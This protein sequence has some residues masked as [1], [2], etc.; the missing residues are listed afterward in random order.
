MKKTI[1]FLTVF[2]LVLAFFSSSFTAN[3]IQ[4]IYS[5][6]KSDETSV[7]VSTDGVKELRFDDRMDITEKKVEVIDDGIPT[8]YQVGYGI[9]E[10]SVF[11]TAVV[12]IQGDTLIATGIGTAVVVIDGKQTEIR[13]TAAPISLFLLIGQSNMRGS[14]GN[15]NQSIACMD[16]TVYS[17]FGDD[18]GDTEGIMNINN[19]TN[20]APSALT[21]EYST[22]N[23]NGNTDNLSYY[24]V[25]SLTES[26][27][28]KFGPD[29]GF[30]YEWVM[31]TGEKVWLVNAAHG[32]SAIASWQPGAVN[33]KEAVSL[34][35][36][37]QETLQKE[38][39][40]GHYTLSHMGYFWCQGCNDASMTAEQ[41][42]AKYLAMHDGLM[43]ALTF[44]HDGDTATD[45]VPFEF[46]G[47]IPILYGMNSYREG[48]YTDVNTRPYYQSFEQLTLN[49]PRVAQYW[50]TNNPNLPEIWNVC[51]I[52]EDWVWM[53]DGT[54]GVGE[55]FN[56][57][58]P[59]GTVNYPTQVPQKAAW[60]TPTTPAAVHDSIHYNQIG[61]NE[62]GRESVRNIL[63]ILGELSVPDIQTSVELLTWDGYTP[64]GQISASMVGKSETLVVPKIYPL[65]K[66]KDVTFTLSE[67]LYWDYYDLLVKDEEISGSL[68]SE[69]ITV[70][71]TGHN[72]SDWETIREA[73]ADGV[74]LQQRTCAHCNGVETREI[75]GV[76]QIYNLNAH[77]LELPDTICCGTNLWAILP[78]EDVHFTSG[79]KWGHVSIPAPSI[80]IPLEPGDKIYATSF[81]AAGDNGGPHNGIRLTFFNA[82]GVAWSV[83]PGAAYK[84]WKNK[85]YIEA[86][87]GTIA[88]NIPMWYDSEAYELYILNREH[89]YENGICTGC[90]AVQPP[91]AEEIITFRIGKNEF[92]AIKG[93]TWA[94][95]IR[96]FDISAGDNGIVWIGYDGHPYMLHGYLYYGEGGIPLGL[97]PITL[98]GVRIRYDD[99]ILEDVYDCEIDRSM[100]Q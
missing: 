93:M 26:G 50:L 36:A 13:V 31:Q 43:S 95:W 80:T 37:C 38:I 78:H 55:Y 5:A 92:T 32:G 97:C 85:G 17:T 87:A 22:V 12:T 24:P 20:F 67:G 71:V 9:E 15:A 98:D 60:Y 28:G 70:T 58:Y 46:A 2:T 72:W 62:V 30:G 42:V 65:W 41:Y 10:N 49:G 73:S 100:P 25:N 88:V 89:C 74:G 27:S 33:F 83:D 66:T 8:S 23:V 21:G 69:N 63:V 29:S 14:E 6:Y 56:V 77:L 35:R 68:T 1:S 96:S 18:R 19:A 45:A 61:Y 39:A 44:D 48:S 91:P 86:P 81:L 52:G 3:S 82:Y 57:H 76:W 40:A 53:P 64:A 47:I 7:T 54:N 4:N 99:T 75:K 59:N 94:E 90:S 51:N 11:D 79:K 84:E 34:F 16:G